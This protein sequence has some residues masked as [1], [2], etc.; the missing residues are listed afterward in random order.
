MA[1]PVT[2]RW[3]KLVSLAGALL[4]VALGWWLYPTDVRRVRAACHEL[5][6]AVS[7]PPQEPDL[8]RAARLAAFARPLSPD[9]LVEVEGVEARL[10]GR[11]QVVAIASRLSASPR[12]MTV[13]LEG[14]D[15]TI[16]EDRQSA[17]ARAVATVREPAPDG[18]SDVV[19]HR[20]VAL[21]WSRSDRGW[22]LV[23]ALVQDAETLR[24]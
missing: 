1:H 20:R 16:G 2:P 8:A 12:G 9:L 3:S 23:H 11:D 10:E 18:N 17:E 5:A 22:Q 4:V 6:H 15:V 19:E 21:R 13:T 14:L 24:R 7:V